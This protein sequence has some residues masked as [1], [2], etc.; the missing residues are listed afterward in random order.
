M[1]RDA[2]AGHGQPTPNPVDLIQLATRNLPA[3][4]PKLRS[5]G[6]RDL[7]PRFE[8]CPHLGSGG[9]EWPARR[10]CLHACWQIGAQPINDFRLDAEHMAAARRRGDGARADGRGNDRCPHGLGRQRSRSGLSGTDPA[11]LAKPALLN[12]VRSRGLD[13]M[14]AVPE[15][16]GPVSGMPWSR[17]A[18]DWLAPS[19]RHRRRATWSLPRLWDWTSTRGPRRWQSPSR[20]A[21]VKCAFWARPQAR[22]KRC[23]AWSSA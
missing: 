2:D 22:R 5:E 19:L 8:A 11:R 9:D 17:V 20:V 18:P 23:I 13:P 14:F 15:P 16:E 7:A 10:R 1:A 21:A 3:S 4:G 12:G 6:D